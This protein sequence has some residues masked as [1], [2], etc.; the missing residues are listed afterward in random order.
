MPLAGPPFHAGRFLE[1][2][3]PV[4]VLLGLAVP[5]SVTDSAAADSAVTT[6]EY[7][8]SPGQTGSHV[9]PAAYSTGQAGHKLKWLPTRTGTASR[10]SRSP[11]LVKSAQYDAPSPVRV[12]ARGTVDPFNMPFG[13]GSVS[14]S[15]QDPA[16]KPVSD[17]ALEG[18]APPLLSR[19]PLELPPGPKP[20]KA[21]STEQSEK[22]TKPSLT[23]ELLT[24]GPSDQAYDCSSADKIRPLS[25]VNLDI[26]PSEA[27]PAPCKRETGDFQGRDW[28][29]TTFMWKASGLCHKPA[30]FEEVQLERYGHSTGPYTQPLV[31]AAHFF[32]TVPVLPYKMGL[33]PPEECMYTLGYYRPGSCAPYLLNPLPLSLRAGVAQAGA[34]T[35]MGLLI[36]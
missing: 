34:M 35:G 29:P 13:Q 25:D 28:A 30:Y 8:A 32:L 4:T 2:L 6:A 9:L 7:N 20:L 3:L 31:S 11:S 1:G 33:Y 10:A 36:P 21:E 14:A 24:V 18:E 26:S 5:L 19:P 17:G 12:A 23:E 16:E 15:G 27:L 22:V